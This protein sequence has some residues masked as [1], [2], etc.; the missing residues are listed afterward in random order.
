MLRK[1]SRPKPQRENSQ[2]RAAKTLTKRPKKANGKAVV[3]LKSEVEGKT[4]VMLRRTIPRELYDMLSHVG[5]SGPNTALRELELELLRHYLKNPEHR[6]TIRVGIAGGG[7]VFLEFSQGFLVYLGSWGS[8]E[9]ACREVKRLDLPAPTIP[10]CV[11]I[12]NRWH[13]GGKK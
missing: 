2:R 3:T 5:L 1:K 8:Y 10:D 12:V 9:M 11:R 6:K 4:K 13:F 7:D